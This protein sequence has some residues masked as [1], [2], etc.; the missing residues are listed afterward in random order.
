M[1]SVIFS[2]FVSSLL[3]NGGVEQFADAFS[4][5]KSRLTT[6]NPDLPTTNIFRD[7]R[8]KDQSGP[9][10]EVLGLHLS[11]NSNP[12]S[13][14][15]SRPT[16]D[17]FALRNIRGDALLQYNTLN[18]SEPLRINL[19]LLLTLSLFAFPTVSE[20]VL[21]EPS[22]LV[23]TAAT[24]LGGVGSFGLFL[25]ECK[26]RSRQLNRIEKELNAEFLSLKLPSNRF[27]DRPLGKTVQLGQLRGS[28]RLLALCGNKD[29][30]QN[31]LVQFRVMRRRLAQAAVIAVIV[32]TDGSTVEEW[33]VR[34]EEIRS[35][36]FLAEAQDIE[37]WVA[38][39]RSLQV[40]GDRAVD[41]NQLVWFG[42]NNNG[43]SFASGA[44]DSPRLIEI[45]GQNLRPLDV[46]D[47][48]DEVDRGS[49]VDEK[50]AKEAAKVLE[51]QARFYR[52]LTDGDLS[53]M[54]EVCSDN[55]ASEV[56]E[57]IN[58]GGRVDDWVTCLADD[59]RPSGMQVS[60]QDVL[61]VSE[62]EAFSTAVEFPANS[63]FDLAT[64]LALQRWKCNSDGDWELDLHQTIPWSPN[65]KAG[66]TLR[67]DCRG[68]VALTRGKDRRTFGG[69]IG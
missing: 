58:E 26:N 40:G 37:N 57:V 22:T 36:P 18:Q 51:A 42:L 2:W 38:Y 60:G 68:C 48:D 3:I 55:G 65:S 8:C 24:A 21:G 34:D 43:R 15:V 32:P 52:A 64:L 20:A 63:G 11:K 61:V 13:F 54:K 5:A 25:R 30:L 16:F 46:L 17:L 35:A 49:T 29:Q 6:R 10:Q 41:A 45:L 12:Y 31:A 7:G 28:K 39:F 4:S 9:R 47:E 44:G 19:Y 59:A 33:G 53:S 62:K 14:D 69:L 1:K 67:C 23:T 66:G 50:R 56:T 27:A